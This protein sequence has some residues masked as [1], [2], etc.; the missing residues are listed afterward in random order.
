MNEKILFV[1]DDPNLLASCERNLRKQFP[2]D[3]AEG[4]QAG[5]EKIADRGPYAVVVSDRQM[6]GMDGIQFLSAVRKRAPETVRIMLTG[7]VDLESAVRVVNE[8]NIFRFLIKPCPPETL[9]TTLK[10]ALEQYRLVTSEKELLSKTLSG[11]IKLL[12]DILSMVDAK[13]FGRSERLRDLINELTR[14][15]AM[16]N[17]WEV[18][19][20]AMLSA[21]GYITLP[22]ETIVK[23]R[24]Q[25]LLS[26]VEEQLVAGVPEIAARLLA[27]IP[28]LEGVAKIVRYQNKRFDGSGYPQDTTRG[29]AIPPGAR[30]LKILLDMQELQADGISPLNA[31]NE[32]QQRKGWYDV[33]LLAIVR[34]A[35]GGADV[36][37]GA[38]KPHVSV[39]VADLTVGMI[40]HSDLL[41]KSGTLML[42]T[43]HR[44][45]PMSLQKIQNFDQLS[46]IKE[47]IFVEAP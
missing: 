3:T 13:S 40:L 24:G 28:R 32:L 4:G 23:A 2:L 41:T 47:P 20:A 11:S 21:I 44:I 29:E 5:L 26:K 42:T 9:S 27:N 25:Q 36:N 16:D 33:N 34:A 18:H 39:T 7:N 35:V 14:K 30:L 17:A 19:L 12:T 46:G 8:G 10:D 31:V 1:D 43:G 15:L 22:P 45:T 38:T 6:P 37:S